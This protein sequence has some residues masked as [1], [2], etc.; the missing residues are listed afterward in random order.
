VVVE[1]D[2]VVK[3]ATVLSADPPDTPENQF[4]ELPELPVALIVTGPVPHLEFGKVLV[5]VGLD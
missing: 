4:N 3:D 5:I 1:I 2:G